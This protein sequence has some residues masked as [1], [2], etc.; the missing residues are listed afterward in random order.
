LKVDG[1]AAYVPA[2]GFLVFTTGGNNEAPLMAQAMDAST[3]RTTGDAIPIVE[4]VDVSSGV[5]AQHQ[6][7]V[8]RDG[9]LAYASTGSSNTAQLTWFDRSGKALGTVGTRGAGLRKPAISPDGSTVAADSLQFG[10]RDIWLHD[11]ARGTSSRF[12]F[13]PA[14]AA[15]FSP[16]WSPDGNYLIFSYRDNSRPITIMRKAIGSGGV[17]E[18]VGSPW[19]DPARAAFSVGW[20]RDS[21]YVVAMLVQGGPTGADIWMLPLNPAGEKPRPYLQSNADEGA[22]SLSPSSDWLAY[23]SDETRRVEVYA[24]SFPNPGRKYQVSVNGGAMPVWSRD[25]KELY[26]IAPDRQ[27]MVVAIKNNGGNLEIGTSKALF[28][29]KIAVSTFAGFD[30]GKDGR[31]LIPVQEQGSTLPM[32]LVVNWQAGLKK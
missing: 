31:F 24:Q 19:G 20:S 26:F 2:G 4:S 21:R 28:D 8:S 30:V 5:W 1:H 25:G 16:A 14:S 3:F 15:A 12:T 17:A 27:M 11:L 23:T 9:V 10:S 22:P 29:S 32:T 18:A 7:S 13:Y 6:F